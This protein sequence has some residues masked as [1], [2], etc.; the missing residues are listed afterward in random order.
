[1]SASDDVAQARAR[2]EE[3]NRQEEADN[4]AVLDGAV[5]NIDESGDQNRGRETELP[6]QND[7]VPR[8]KPL[9]MSPADEVRANIAKRFRHEAPEDEVPFNG[10]MTDPEMLYG[11]AGRREE[12]PAGDDIDPGVPRQEAQTEAPKLRKLIVRG[13]E[14]E[15]TEEEI[16]ARAGKVT[17]ADSY[18]D[19][20]RAML[21]EAKSIRGGRSPAGTD[22]HPD[23]SRTRATEDEQE[24]DPPDDAQHPAQSRTRKLVEELQFGDPDKAA[25]LLE[26]IVDE[27]ADKKADNRQLTRLMNND[28]VASQKALKDFMGKHPEL[29]DDKNAAVLIENSMYDFFREEIEALGTVDKDTIPKD[30][31]QLANWHRFH[32][33]HGDN[34]S[35][36]ADLLEKA[37]KKIEAWRGGP[38]PNPSTSRSTERRPEP[39]VDVTVDRTQRRQALPNQPSRTVSPRPD[40]MAAPQTRSR[41]DVVMQMRKSRGQLTAG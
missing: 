35:K 32:R 16:L 23:P 31:K 41:S 26:E 38:K 2:Q 17:A 15:L 9:Y 21:E 34:V 40:A 22:Q 18:L 3:Q 5:D 7:D 33:V 28:L 14:I 11:R 30:P 29:A 12:E 25:E 1:M 6:E 4:R 24:L 27:R 36:P 10:D 13:K 20:A 8:R 37:L 39:R 19:E